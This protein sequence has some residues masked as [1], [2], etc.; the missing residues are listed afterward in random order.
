M[1]R[2]QGTKMIYFCESCDRIRVGY[3]GGLCDACLKTTRP[4]SVV[5]AF[6]KWVKWLF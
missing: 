3:Y 6:F 2:I 5:K 1:N 4:V